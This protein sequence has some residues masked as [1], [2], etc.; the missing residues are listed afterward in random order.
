MSSIATRIAEAKRRNT[1]YWTRRITSQIECAAILE[2][3][4][5]AEATPLNERAL[6]VIEQDGTLVAGADLT[7]QLCTE[8]EA[9]LSP[10]SEIAKKYSISCVGHAHID[11]NW[12]WGWPETVAITTDTFRTVLDLM[13]DYPDFTFAQSQA[14]CYEIVEEHDPVRRA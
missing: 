2:E 3:T 8:I 9:I 14:S 10:L 12:M 6:T 13:N 1:G 4:D 11:M 5:G 7:Q